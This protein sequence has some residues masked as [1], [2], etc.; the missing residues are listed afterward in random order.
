MK[1]VFA[2]K[3]TRALFLPVLCASCLSV[4]SCNDER[5]LLRK[6][7]RQ[8]ISAEKTCSYVTAEQ[9]RIDS[10]VIDWLATVPAE[11]R[12]AQ[13]FLVNL[14]GNEKFYPVEY[15]GERKS[16]IRS[17]LIP[18]GYIFFSYNLAD[19]PDKIVAFTDSIRTFCIQN[20]CI[21]PYLSLDQEGGFV[22]RLQG[23]AGPLPAQN[24][25][26]ECL[27]QPQA[28]RLYSLQAVQMKALGFS[29]NLA[30]VAEP[31]SPLNSNFLA[32]RSFGTGKAAELYGA[33]AV[34]GFENNGV[35]AVLKHF[36]GNTNTDP[37]TGLP[38]IN[39][40]DK[41]LDELMAP[42]FRLVRYR[43]SGILMSLARTAAHDSEKPS[44]LSY[45]WVTQIV[46]NKMNFDGLIISDD[47]FMGALADN[48]F[49]SETAGIMAVQAGVNCIMISEKRFAAQEQVLIKRA[50]A[51]KNFAAKLEDSVR[52]III[53]KIQN[54]ILRVENDNGRIEIL[55]A[56]VESDSARLDTF[57]AAKE[58][59]RELYREYFTGN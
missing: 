27:T 44:C 5:K 3:I 45:Y 59:N 15:T 24:R 54:G 7:L 12:Y 2:G 17:P 22:Q 19:S 58:E 53:W 9:K 26:A 35:A 39:I 38:E 31:L 41:E 36:P 55:P 56:P 6:E 23:I 14:A 42:F 51:D 18:G 46:R 48:G 28:Y 32:D 50:D 11:Q 13:L 8:R 37:H 1:F 4:F 57:K 52:R 20:S 47:I 34:N 10:A 33:A 40:S 43:P 49:D 25:V 16:G 29:L 21:P 30:P